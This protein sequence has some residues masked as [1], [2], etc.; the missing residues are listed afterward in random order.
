MLIFDF[1]QVLVDSQA[2]V[3]LRDSRRWSEYRNRLREIPPCEGISEVLADA[4]DSGH[5][6]AI[7]THSPGMVPTEYVRNKNWPINIIVGWHDYRARKPN[8]KGIQLAM[9]KGSAVPENTYHI[10]DQPSDTE[11]ARR[12]GIQSIGAAWAATD[13]KALRLSEPDHYC[14]TVTDLAAFISRLPSS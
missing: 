7:V 1:D 2:L 9:Q 6:L 5:S 3:Y 10:G 8:P 13:P 4:H 11:A 14:E 12:A